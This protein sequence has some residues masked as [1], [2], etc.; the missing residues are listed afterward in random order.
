MF[1]EELPSSALFIF[2]LSKY[3]RHLWGVDR[4]YKWRSGTNCEAELR[5]LDIWCGW[6]VMLQVMGYD[7]LWRIVGVMRGRDGFR[8]LSEI[9]HRCWG[10]KFSSSHGCYFCV[11]QLQAKETLSI[12][13]PSNMLTG[14]CLLRN[15]LIGIGAVSRCK[16]LN[17]VFWCWNQVIPDT[18]FKVGH[19]KDHNIYFWLLT[20]SRERPYLLQM[21]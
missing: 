14:I 10:L 3:R 1:R 5:L 12:Q 8:K 21:C 6:H 19:L 4:P 7:V 13:I 20:I 16:Y 18:R 15:S 11:K 17:T 2:C 9:P